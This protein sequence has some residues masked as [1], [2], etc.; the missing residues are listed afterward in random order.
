MREVAGPL[1]LVRVH[2]SKY[3]DTVW[4]YRI[5]CDACPKGDMSAR[6]YRSGQPNDYWTALGR[7]AKHLRYAH[8]QDD[9]PCLH[10]GPPL[11]TH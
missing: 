3:D 10:I 11:T 5:V 4:I 6:T 1:A 2:P 9:A 7:W 8:P